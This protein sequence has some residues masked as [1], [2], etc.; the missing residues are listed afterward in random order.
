VDFSWTGQGKGFVLSGYNWLI[1]DGLFS[2]RQFLTRMIK[3]KRGI[4]NPALQG[5]LKL[6][7]M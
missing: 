4:E 2:I 1:K 6:V 5:R 7:G 3:L